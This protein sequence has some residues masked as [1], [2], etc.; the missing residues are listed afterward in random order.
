MMFSEEHQELILG[1]ITIYAGKSEITVVKMIRTVWAF[2]RGT[3]PR[4]K[5]CTR[6]NY[7]S[8]IPAD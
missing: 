5:I 2:V 8:K 7:I 1:V 6:Q 4:V 3:R